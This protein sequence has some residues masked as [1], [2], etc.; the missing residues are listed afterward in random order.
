MTLQFLLYNFM[1][2]LSRVELWILHSSYF[3]LIYFLRV[4]SLAHFYTTLVLSILG[5][6]LTTNIRFIRDTLFFLDNDLETCL[7]LRF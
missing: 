3:H 4:D 7:S 6:I 2:D 5:L 1:L